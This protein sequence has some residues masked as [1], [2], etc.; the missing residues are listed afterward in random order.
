MSVSTQCKDQTQTFSFRK[1]RS[2]EWKM[3]I[4]TKDKGETK[5]RKY[6]KT[7]S[8]VEYTIVE[9]KAWGLTF[10]TSVKQIYAF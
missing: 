10:F 6:R 7:A 2:A 8:S 1:L 5:Y 3:V 9:K 4:Q